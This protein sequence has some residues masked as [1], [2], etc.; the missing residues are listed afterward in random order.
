MAYL[1]LDCYEVYRMGLPYCPKATCNGDTIIEVDELMLPTIL[2]LNQKG[3]CTEYCC[4]GHAYEGYYSP[5]IVF[6][7]FLNEMLSEIE[8]KELFKELPKPWQIESDDKFGRVTL[9]YKVD[10]EVQRDIVE[11]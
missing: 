1:C 3:Y 11:S 4:S 10:R 2:L 8:L 7:S 5:Y 6:D 9:R